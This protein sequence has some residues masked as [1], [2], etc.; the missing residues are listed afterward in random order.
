MVESYA[1]EIIAVT[2]TGR[3]SMFLIVFLIL[4]GAVYQ[5][6]MLP[7]ATQQAIAAALG[8]LIGL[9]IL[10][11]ACWKFPKLLQE[12]ISGAG[13]PGFGP[14]SIAAL[15]GGLGGYWIFT[16]IVVGRAVE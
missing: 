16:I 12:V 11:L 4:V 2:R 3:I 10:G 6:R 1:E 5:L 14:V 7:I 15:L 13:Y 8:M 9:A